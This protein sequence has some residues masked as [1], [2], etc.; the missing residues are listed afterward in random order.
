MVSC[1]LTKDLL[2]GA[3]F[4]YKVETDGDPK[5]GHKIK[6]SKKSMSYSGQLLNGTILNELDTLAVGAVTMKKK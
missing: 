3:S 4:S 1:G 6:G 5:K 2:D